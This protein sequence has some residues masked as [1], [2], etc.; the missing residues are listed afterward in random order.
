MEVTL[1]Q[2]NPLASIL[3][4]FRNIF[5]LVGVLSFFINLLSFTP[6]VYML[7]I[8]DRILH[9]RSVETLIAITAI[10]IFIYM[11]FGVALWGRSIIM[12]RLGNNIDLKVNQ[13]LFNAA[14]EQALKNKRDIRP[15]DVFSDLLSV[16][17]FLTGQGILT[18]FDI[19]WTVMAIA[20]MFYMHPIIGSFGIVS[21]CILSLMVLISELASRKSIEEANIHS[22]TANRLLDSHLRNAEVIEAMGMRENIAKQWLPNQLK[23]LWHQSVAS[24]RAASLSSITRVVRMITQSLILGIVAWLTIKNEATP[25][26]VIASSVLLGRALAPIDQA[27]SMWRQFV[28]ARNAYRRLGKTMYSLSIEERKISLPTPRG[29]IEV[30]SLSVIPPGGST[31]VIKNVSFEVMPGE[32]IA[33]L[34]PSA[35]GK[36]TLVKAI[37]GVW[38]PYTGT[39]RIDGADLSQWNRS[40]L[41]VAIGYLPQDVELLPG[42]VAMNIARFGSVYSNSGK[43]IKAAQMVGI[44]RMILQLPK[45]YNTNLEEVVLSGGQR[46]RIALA[47][48]VYGD[49]RL[50]VLDEP[51]V[52]LDG[53]GELALIRVLKTLR[54]SG[55]TVIIVTH[56]PNLLSSVDK[57]LVLLEGKV[58]IYGSRDEVLKSARRT[59]I[60]DVPPSIETSSK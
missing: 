59:P 20:A 47:R 52:H 34:G 55:T 35:S 1:I 33:I 38:R 30:Q 8:Y 37:V 9:S 54:E 48:A 10:V 36:S 50:V 24:E 58:Y 15:S 26:M 5:L 13:K 31:P 39:V 60:D 25:G 28:L 40:E 29:H 7:Q 57:I 42:T 56:R 4:E 12:I 27:V 32:A 43:I 17:Q 14:F 11:I 44:H 3:T 46:Q 18:F 19:P 2:R 45:G 22:R 16:R 51:D 49:P 53:E 41:G 6:V 23:M 21:I